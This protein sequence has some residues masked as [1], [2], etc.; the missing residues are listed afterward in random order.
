MRYIPIM[1]LHWLK[2]KDLNNLEKLKVS[3]KFKKGR[4]E[5]EAI[6]HEIGFLRSYL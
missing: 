2:H 1:Y 5:K 4:I 3:L 6:K